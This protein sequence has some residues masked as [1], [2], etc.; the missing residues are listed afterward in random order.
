MNPEVEKLIYVFSIVMPIAA[1]LT[2]DEPLATF[3]AIGIVAMF[4][5]PR[6]LPR[7]FGKVVY[8]VGLGISL[9]AALVALIIVIAIIAALSVSV[10]S[11]ILVVIP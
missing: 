6:F 9:L 11:A 4:G 3:I 1:V 10:W 5:G 8:V 7:L 2:A